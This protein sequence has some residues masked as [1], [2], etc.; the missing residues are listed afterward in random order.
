MCRTIQK[1]PFAAVFLASTVAVA[2]GFWWCHR[3]WMMDDISEGDTAPVA[4]QVVVS[5]AVGLSMSAPPVL[6]VW[7]GNTLV[8]GIGSLAKRK[9]RATGSPRSNPRSCFTSSSSS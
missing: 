8:V 2:L 4:L 1:H 3:P 5:L 9:G 7:G 6:L